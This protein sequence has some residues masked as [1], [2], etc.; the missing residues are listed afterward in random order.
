MAT[1]ASSLHHLQTARPQQKFR[2]ELASTPAEREQCYQ[3]RYQV[4]ANELGAEVRGNEPGLDKDRFDDHCCHIAV[5]DNRTNQLVATT[6]L[7]DNRGRDMTGVF[8][9]ETEFDISRILDSQKTYLEVGRTCIHPA[10]R[11]GAALPMLW[12]GIARYVVENRIDYLFGCASIPLA[13][14][15][16]Y[17][18]SVMTHL[19]DKHF[20]TESLRVRPLIPLR[21]EETGPFPDDVILPTLLKAYL[22]QG[23]VICGE[24]YWDAGF[25]VA[26]VFVLL[27][28]DQITNRYAKHFIDR[29]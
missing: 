14:G 13:N 10:Y 4:F 15:N 21:L 2:V 28:C 16:K 12:Q 6:R 17:I 22:R 8:Y 11:R 20:S 7:L 5:F 24:P 27:Q 26:D 1:P 19:R 29:I 23:A 3:L 18:T 25:G 9:S